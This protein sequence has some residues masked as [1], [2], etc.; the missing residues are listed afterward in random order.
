MRRA[1]LAALAVIVVLVAGVGWR[2]YADN[3][4]SG[5]ER[6]TAALL[7]DA[8]FGNGPEAATAFGDASKWL[9]DEGRSCD[10]T[11]ADRSRSCDLRMSAAAYTGVAAFVL[12][13][14]TA[15]GVDAARR[16]LLSYLRAIERF[17]A[18]PVG[19]VELPSPPDI[20]KC[21]GP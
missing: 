7:D 6:T 17:D 16:S 21:E 14:C 10:R 13:E 2:T 18:S 9:F 1:A 19:T 20:P 5:V 12:A 3:R 11:D 8:K 15:P 4:R